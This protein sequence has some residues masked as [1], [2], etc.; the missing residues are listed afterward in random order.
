M[1]I[2]FLKLSWFGKKFKYL[3]WSILYP[4]RI[5]LN[6]SK[7]PGLFLTNSTYPIFGILAAKPENFNQISHFKPEIGQQYFTIRCLY[8]GK[9]I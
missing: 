3:Y 4:I 8:E 5:Q 9:E 6:I 1:I 2:I 7:S